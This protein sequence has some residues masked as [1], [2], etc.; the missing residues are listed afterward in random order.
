[1]AKGQH[2]RQVRHT[3]HNCDPALL[4]LKQSAVVAMRQEGLGL[5]DIA[6]RIDRSIGAVQGMLG[7]AKKIQ[8]AWGR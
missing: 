6:A 7:R 8:E 3:F 2:T 4:T 1:M 5:R